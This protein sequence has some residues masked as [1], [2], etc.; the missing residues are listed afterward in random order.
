MDGVRASDGRGPGEDAELVGAYLRHARTRADAAHVELLREH[1]SLLRFG[2]RQ[3]TYQHDE[4]RALIRLRLVRG[5]REGWA[6]LET[7]DGD[8][9]R[10]TIDRLAAALD[11]LPAGAPAAM[12]APWTRPPGPAAACDET[13][14]VSPAGRAHVFGV[15]A[16]RI[17][18]AISLGGSISTRVTDTIV[19]NTAGLEVAEQRTRAAL[20]VVA[21]GEHGST[22]VRR[23]DTCWGRIDPLEAGLAAAAGVPDRSALDL[24]DGPVRVLLGP[25]AVATFAATLAHIGLGA[26][27]PGG[28]VGPF[29]ITTPAPLGSGGGS[30]AVRMLSGLVTFRDDAHDPAGLPAAFDCAGWPKHA[31]TLVEAGRPVGVVHDVRTAALAG[32][33]PTGHTAPPGWRFG[34]GP[35]PSHLIVSAGDHDPDDLLRILGDGLVIERVDY[36]R[37]VQPRQGLVTGTTR[38]GTRRVRGG[39]V[40]GPAPQFRFTVGLVDLFRSIEAVGSRREQGEAPFID[41][42]VAPAMVSSAFPIDAIARR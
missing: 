5:D 33:N 32:T 9:V 20:Q 27:G 25:Q 37:V 17:P 3:I 35:S 10:A 8:R 38:D 36:V 28:T 29:G 18:G 6:L 24:P 30:G 16:E 1:L 21:T 13:L 22:F 40:I 34:S 42:V 31:V 7:A 11:L 14:A 19:A 26:V 12:P 41:A 2:N 4:E 15:L 23:I 39:R